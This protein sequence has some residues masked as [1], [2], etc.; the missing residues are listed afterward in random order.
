MGSADLATVDD[1][2][3]L[4]INPATLSLVKN[5]Q[6]DVYIVGITS[7]NSN[8][9][10]MFGND[11]DDIITNG[12]FSSIGYAHPINNNFTWGA[13]FN[14]IGGVGTEIK[15]INT[16]FGTQDDYSVATSIVGFSTGLS[17]KIKDRLVIGGSL[18][19]NYSQTEQKNFPDTSF[20]NS[21][22]TFFGQHIKDAK[23]TSYSFKLGLLHHLNSSTRLAAAYKS[24]A[25]L[26][27]NDGT[28]IFDMSAIG[29]GKVTYNKIRLKSIDQPQEIGIGLSHQIN[30]DWLL[31][32]EINWLDWSSAARSLS[33]RA[34]STDN[35]FAPGQVGSSIPLNWHDQYVFAF[36]AAY[37]IGQQRKILMGINLA[38][39]PVPAKNMSPSLSAIAQTHITAGYSHPFNS[40]HSFH[41]AAEYQLKAT[42][43]YTNSTLPFGEDTS[44]EFDIFILHFLY[45]YNW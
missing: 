39:N 7:F 14:V 34:S 37:H 29:L 30:T 23:T 21:D 36:G 28:A 35:A 5:K 3:A 15:N 38:N 1:S 41:L 27:I 4:I 10:D 2:T 45:S 8:H 20:N 22:L 40:H 26:S 11:S 12:T 44:I 31:A 43:T 13:G 19:L 25:D 32:A 24:K 33:I 18:I 9:S 42:A 17:W 6:L 16:A